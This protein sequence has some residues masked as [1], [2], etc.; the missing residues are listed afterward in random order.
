MIRIAPYAKAVTAALVAFLT[1]LATALDDSSISARE[2]V[3]ALIALLVAGGAVF[4]VRNRQPETGE[5]ETGQLETGQP[6]T[7]Q[8]E[9]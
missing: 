8:P 4:T 5:L 7:G 1:A 9:T 2:W 6:E 3:T